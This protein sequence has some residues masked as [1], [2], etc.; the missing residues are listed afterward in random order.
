MPIF[1]SDLQGRILAAVLLNPD[2]EESL[3][4]L[5]RRADG[6]LAAVQ[7]EVDRLERAGVVR[8]R[9]MGNTRL[10]GATPDSPL[11]PELSGLVLKAFG[12]TIVLSAALRAVP[13]VSRAFVFG[14]WAARYRGEDGP[15]PGD[16]DV[17]V[18]GRPD[19]DDV[20]DALRRASDRSGLP[21]N[22]VVRS[23]EAWAAADDAFARSVK[24]GPVIELALCGDD[25]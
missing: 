7:R 1:R 8:S 5:A 22:A 2:Q 3:T 13:D 21:V 16:V 9:K 18:L 12:P 19:R 20:D 4:G 10:V 15:R 23:P 24:N 14:S 17:M 6:S 25:V 11:E